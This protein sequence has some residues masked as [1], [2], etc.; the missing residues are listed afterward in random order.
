MLIACFL[1]GYFVEKDRKMYQGIIDTHA[2]Y[3]DDAYDEDREV[4]IK[5]FKDNRIE[6]VINAGASLRGAYDSIELSKKH[7][8]FYAVIGIHPDELE[9]ITKRDFEDLFKKTEMEKVIGIGEIGLD[10]YNHVCDK[11]L[12]EKWFRYQLEK[13]VELDLPVVIHSRDAEADTERILKEYSDRL[14]GCEL[15][16]YSYSKESA[17][18]FVKLGFYFGIGGVS[19]FKNAKKLVEALEV[20]PLDRIFLETDAPYLTPV[21]Y[22]GKRNSSLYLSYVVDA[23]A[24]IKGISPQELVKIT[25]E[26]VKRFYGLER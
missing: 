1:A 25:N 22:R 23:V 5:D 24:S 13:A 26:N 18:V 10:Y 14:K 12:Q 16:C 9:G 20:I 15:H 6:M 2:H 7:D 11:S 4:L 17:K 21:P 3:D 19:T 8:I